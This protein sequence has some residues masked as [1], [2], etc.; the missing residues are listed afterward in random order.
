V[1]SSAAQLTLSTAR[2]LQR[3]WR[4]RRF[5]HVGEGTEVLGR[6]DVHG[7]GE[8][9]IGDDVL[10]DGS[11]V[12][13][14]LISGR[15]ARL[16]IGDG[17]RV[18][19]GVSIEAANRIEI[20]AGVRIGAFCK[21]LDNH[22]HPVRG[23]RHRGAPQSKPVIVED[24]VTLEERVILLPGAHIQRGTTITAGSVITRKVPAHAV[25]GGVTPRLIRKKEPG[26]ASS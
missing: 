11:L 15:G 7:R 4:S 14:E 5:A 19:G 1:T 12:G 6:L 23:D 21:L 18:A 2:W 24:G 3:R 26:E 16:S 17:T 20:G 9:V 25:I 13:V 8:I 10:L 22:L